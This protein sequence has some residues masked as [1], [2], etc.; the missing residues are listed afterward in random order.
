MLFFNFR[1]CFANFKMTKADGDNLVSLGTAKK[2]FKNSRGVYFP[3]NRKLFRNYQKTV[4]V[5]FGTRLKSIN[6]QK[7]GYFFL[8]LY[9]NIV[10]KYSLLNV[11]RNISSKGFIFSIFLFSLI[12]KK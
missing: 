1:F 2:P 4:P 12:F 9:S 3:K 7:G 10:A 11:Q 5:F 6:E 8:G